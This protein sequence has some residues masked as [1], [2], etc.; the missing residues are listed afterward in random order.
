MVKATKRCLKALGEY[1]DM[2]L[3]EFRTFTVRVASL[4]NGR[5]ISKAKVDGSELILTPNHFLVGNLG[6]AVDTERPT[7]LAQRWYKVHKLLNQFWKSFLETYLKELRQTRKWTSLYDNVKPGALVLEVDLNQPRG[8][9]KTAVVKEV[10]PS[11]D[12]LTRRAVIK[13]SRGEYTRPIVNLV[14]L[15]DP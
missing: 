7:S 13:N 6:G 4:L 11:K 9:W 15:F 12:G 3:D 14:P 10:L 5:P 2:T 1:S 8:S